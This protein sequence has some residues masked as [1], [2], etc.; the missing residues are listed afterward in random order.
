[1]G[2]TGHLCLPRCVLHILTPEEKFSFVSSD[3]KG[4]VNV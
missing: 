3:P 2:L 4:Q 1:M